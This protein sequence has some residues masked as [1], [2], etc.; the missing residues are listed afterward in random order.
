MALIKCQECHKEISDSAKRCPLCGYKK[1]I[2]ISRKIFIYPIIILCS[3]SI[4]WM[5]IGSTIMNK[6]NLNAANEL[7]NSTIEMIYDES[8]KLEQYIDK[9]YEIYDSGGDVTYYWQSTK[10]ETDDFLNTSEIIKK[11]V[12]ELHNQN[13]YKE[14]KSFYD[15]YKDLLTMTM[16]VGNDSIRTKYNNARVEFNK[17]YK[18]LKENN[19]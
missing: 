3:I 9:A 10:E 1:K 15:S 19:N 12:D 18:K 11:N 2:E 4:F 7:Y 16:T 8:L 17:D 5:I 14:L 13:Y 6:I